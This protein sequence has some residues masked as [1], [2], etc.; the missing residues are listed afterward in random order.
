MVGG[1]KQLTC[2]NVEVYQDVSHSNL[3]TPVFF[4]LF[5]F[6]RF[7]PCSIKCVEQQISFGPLYFS[8]FLFCSLS[9]FPSLFLSPFVFISLFL[10]FNLHNHFNFL[11]LI[12][13]FIFVCNNVLFS[14]SLFFH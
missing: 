7:T 10:F 14:F 9:L 2:V 12:T 4:F 6:F 13:L 8:F 3:S 1:T 11:C 5:L